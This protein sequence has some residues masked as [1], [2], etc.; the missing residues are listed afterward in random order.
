M[1]IHWPLVI[2]TTCQRVGLGVFVCTWLTCC[3]GMAN[4]QVGQAAFAALCLL[5][6]GALASTFHL[7][8]PTRILNAFANPSS[9][10]TQEGMIT[11][12]L[13]VALVA[14][15]LN[16]FMYDAGSFG[17]V[18]DA[19]AALLS[20]AFLVCTGFAYQMR[21]RP[22]WNTLFIVALFLATSF[23]AGSI[24]VFFLAGGFSFACWVVALFGWVLCTGIQVAYIIRM[25][26]VGYG[27][28]V[29]VE[30]QPYRTPFL[31]WCL[32]SFAGLG[33]LLVAYLWH[34][35]AVVSLVLIAVSVAAWTVLFFKGARKVKMFPMYPGDLNLDM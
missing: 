30:K 17:A 22:A 2:S 6:F 33:M 12:F 32:T 23:E 31:V 29:Y 28:S 11:P 10:L 5:G 34:M 24:G 16:G 20:L 19:V 1:E 21:S 8:R 15:M 9:H 25:R 18:I 4:A 35:A 14:C 27:V 3:L 13:G 7:Q 26:N